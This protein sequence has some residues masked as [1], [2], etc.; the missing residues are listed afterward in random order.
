MRLVVEETGEFIGYEIKEDEKK[1]RIV[2]GDKKLAYS[3]GRF[4]SECQA[5]QFFQH[6]AKM[7][8]MEEVKR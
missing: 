6:L 1:P 3:V 5:D 8:N 7:I 4:N 2:Y